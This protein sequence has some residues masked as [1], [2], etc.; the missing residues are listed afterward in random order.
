M[1]LSIICEQLF[2]DKYSIT[3]DGKDC[4]VIN[5]NIPFNTLS[6]IKNPQLEFPENELVCGIKLCNIPGTVVIIYPIDNT[7]GYFLVNIKG[8]TDPTIKRLFR[9]LYISWAQK[10]K[11]NIKFNL[12]NILRQQRERENIQRQDHHEGDEHQ[13]PEN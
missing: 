7:F 9:K 8:I 6:H 3:P 4:I 12:E 13:H 10:Y 2:F 11:E 5:C 1:D